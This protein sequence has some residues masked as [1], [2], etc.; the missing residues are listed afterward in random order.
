MASSPTRPS[1]PA[2]GSQQENIQ[3]PENF[4]SPDSIRAMTDT[5]GITPLH[6]DATRELVLSMCN[7]K[8]YKFFLDLDF[9]CRQNTQ[10]SVFGNFSKMPPN[11][12][13]MANV[14]N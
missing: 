13:S 7:S 14:K 4:I 8:N 11:T 12:Q 6:E 10:P 1:S 3:V 2:E 5:L 9:L